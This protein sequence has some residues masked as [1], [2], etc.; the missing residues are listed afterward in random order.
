[1]RAGAPRLAALL[2]Q[3]A[4]GLVAAPAVTL[5][6]DLALTETRAVLREGTFAV[7]MTV[8][9]DALLLGVGP[10]A[11][12]AE[13]AAAVRALPPAE[14]DEKLVGL[15]GLFE[16]RVRVFFDGERAPFTVSFP[17]YGT[18]AGTPAAEASAVPTVLGLTA[19]LEGRIPSGARDFT[20]RASRSFPPVALTILE[21]GSHLPGDAGV[22]QLL[23]AGGDSDPYRLGDPSRRP[24]RWRV[25]GRYLELG[26][27]HIVPDG[28][29]HVLF[30][31]GL[32]LLSARLKPLLWQVTAFTLAHTV[33]LA[34]S[35]FGVV[36]LP[37]SIVEP[38]IALSIAWVAVEN[39]LTG[40]LKP[41]RPALVFAFGL[42]HGLGFAGVLAELGLPAGE[43]ATALLA[44]NAGVELGQLAVIAA[45]FLAVGWLRD[46]PWYRA[47]IVVPA[48][49]AI[50]A[51]GLFWAIER[52][53]G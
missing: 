30:V 11:D 5:A 13:V 21:E 48:S 24:S 1:M 17:D 37:P 31:L 38:A 22:R 39:V 32:F 40:E 27:R 2:V 44:F 35:T 53:A 16:R 4:A 3:L 52:L 15:R 42:L 9:L 20:F 18:R 6:H 51:V 25:A 49:L 10:A 26:F 34:L 36:S 14:F 50:A 33:T 7:D 8:D 41:W 43:R 19:R 47:R 23:E 45:A 28:L 12:S 29:D 46:R